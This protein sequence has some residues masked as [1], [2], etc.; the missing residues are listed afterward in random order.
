MRMEGS[1]FWKTYRFFASI[2]RTP[3]RILPGPPSPSWVFGNLKEIESVEGTL[4]PDR[5][6]EQY[7]GHFVDHDFFMTPRLWTMDP[8]AIHHVFTHY[9][10][11]PGPADSR[12]LLTRIF[13]E[14]LFLAQGEEHRRQRKLMNP[15]FGPAQ[16]RDLTGIFVEKSIQLRDLWARAVGDGP[17]QINVM[18]DLTK[19]TLDV[20]GAA[21]F[22]YDFHALG[23]HGEPTELGAAFRRI[24]AKNGTSLIGQLLGRVPIMWYLPLEGIKS[25]KRASNAMFD[26]GMRLVQQK[27]AAVAYWQAAS[28]KDIDSLE[29]K[30]LDGR[31]VLTLLIKANMAKDVPESQRLSDT[32]VVHQIPTFLLAG[33]VTTSHSATWALYAL[34]QKPALQQ[35]LREELLTVPTETPSMDEL[36]ALPFLD[37]VVRE[38]LRLY[39]PITMIVREAMK[40]DVIPLSEP[41]TD[42]FG[43]VH[44]GIKIAKGN[45]V[46]IPILAIHRSKMIWGEDALEFKPARWEHPPAAIAD[47]PGVWSHLLT[48]IGGPRACIGYRFSLVELKA[49]L[50]HLVRSFEFELAVPPEEI[51]TI[52]ASLQRPT[53]RN[54]PHAGPQLPLKVTPYKRA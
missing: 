12:N 3:L 21:G 44:Y 6:F 52:T 33:H 22:N 15:A 42:R 39:A 36:N 28:G 5:W 47:M 14:G 41:F 45:R 46:V 9:D 20:I 24:F 34:S 25:V 8:R 2:Y 23:P 29:R 10:D 4:L 37:M 54:M 40:D 16:I 35:K 18:E 13:G 1:P 31:D 11:Y 49:I 17:K 38:T 53:L 51:A 19:M 7:G 27:K 26:V 32:A 43:N 50:F 30:D 48:F